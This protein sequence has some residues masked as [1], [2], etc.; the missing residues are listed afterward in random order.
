MAGIVKLYDEF[1]LAN[2]KCVSKRA[3]ESK[4]N[5]ITAGKHKCEASGVSWGQSA[6]GQ[7][8]FNS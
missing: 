8:I 3:F 4:L 2:G 6:G 1:T 5:Q 7:G